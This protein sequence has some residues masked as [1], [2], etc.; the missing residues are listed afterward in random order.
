MTRHATPGRSRRIYRRAI[1][2]VLV[3][4]GCTAGITIMWAFI[5]SRAP[6]EYEVSDHF[7]GRRFI[8]PTLSEQ[9]HPGLSDVLGMITEGRPTWPNDV[10]TTGSPQMDTDLDQDGMAVTF[11]NHATFLIQMPGVTILT[12]PVW[13]DRASPVSWSGPRRVRAPGVDFDALPAVDVVVISHNHYDHLDLPT[14]QRLNARFSPQFVV[15][16]GNRLLLESIGIS[17][18]RE[19]DWWESIDALSGTQI[20]L[21]PAQHSSGRGLFDRGRSLW[22]SFFIKR[23]SRSLYFGGDAGYSTHFADIRERLGAP[24]IALLSIGAYEPRWF[25]APLHMNPAEAVI[26][27]RDLAAGLSIGMHFGTFQV[28]AEGFDSPWADLA[29]ALERHAIA[30][31]SFITFPEGDTWLVS[32]QGD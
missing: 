6:L 1:L 20:V 2:V 14:L 7:D 15:P 22:G 18:V 8:N 30:P 12:D 11:V 26:A 23:G 25:M 27:H 9:L 19:L 28:A 17:E 5:K 13:S 3:L 16:L 4:L 29:D 24:E 10:A 21:T 32:R 31:E